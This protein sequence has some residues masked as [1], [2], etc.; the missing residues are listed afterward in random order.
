MRSTMRMMI[1]SVP[2]PIY[3]GACLLSHN[4]ASAQSPAFA[5]RPSPHCPSRANPNAAGAGAGQAGRQPPG[6]APR[7]VRGNR[8]SSPVMTTATRAVPDRAEQ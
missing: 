5:L 3:M 7:S 8:A 4:V 6:P 2:R 1:T